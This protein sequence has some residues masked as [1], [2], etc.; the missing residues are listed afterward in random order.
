MAVI[1]KKKGLSKT[2]QNIPL[3]ILLDQDIPAIFRK[4]GLKEKDIK[5]MIKNNP[6]LMTMAECL[7]HVATEKHGKMLLKS[8]VPVVTQSQ[9]PAKDVWEIRI[10]SA[11]SERGYETIQEMLQLEELKRR[12]KYGIED[13]LKGCNRQENKTKRN[14]TGH[15]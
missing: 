15:A 10:L 3:D 13:I 1:K 9:S 8:T 4:M 14:L 7:R 2:S 6:K 12:L 5:K 11:A